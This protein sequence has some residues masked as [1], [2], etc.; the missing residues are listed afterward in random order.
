MA[1]YMI[2]HPKCYLGKLEEIIEIEGEL[3]DR[4][5]KFVKLIEESAEEPEKESSKKK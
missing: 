3:D 4:S 1:K 2:V 5:T